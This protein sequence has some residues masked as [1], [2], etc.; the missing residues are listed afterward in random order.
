[1]Q[2]WSGLSILWHCLSLGLEWKLTFSILVVTAEF[3]KFAGISFVF[4]TKSLFSVFLLR[5]FINT[6]LYI[7][8][9]L[10]LNWHPP[11]S[12]SY[13]WKWK[14]LSR[15]QL[16]ATPWTTAHGILQARI[17]EWVGFPFSRGSSQPRDQ[18]QVTSIVGRIFT[19]W[20][21]GEA[22]ELLVQFSSVT[23]SCPT[24][25]DPMNCSMPGLPVHH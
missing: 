20:A 13:W 14:S 11:T 21:T 3:S 6:N 19:S 16:Y 17:L 2:L 10:D 1:M 23:Q 9:Q 25:S 5:K 18:T 8:F 24:L 12:E 22:Q 4:P 7:S 15:V